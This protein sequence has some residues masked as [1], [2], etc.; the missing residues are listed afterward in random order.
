[1][2]ICLSAAMLMINRC[3]FI[4]LILLI[5]PFYGC[6][7]SAP[8]NKLEI[9]YGPSA[10]IQRQLTDAELPAL[11][12]NK[13]VSYQHEVKPILENRC[14]AC[15]ACYDAPCQLKLSAFDGL[16]RGASKAKVYDSSRM[17]A[18][19]PTRLFTDASTV[20]QWRDRDFFPILNE[21][22]E[23]KLANLDNSLLAKFLQLKRLN[24]LP[25][26]G[27]LG[28]E[29]TLQ[30][31][32]EESCTKM[33]EYDAFQRK[34]PQWGMPYALPGLSLDQEYTL[35]RWLQQGARIEPGA[36]LSQQSLVAIKRWET[37]FNRPSL[38]QQLVS[39]YIYEHLFIGHLYFQT[40]KDP[41][42]F[43]LVRSSTPPG[44]PIQ[45]IASA[46]PYDD[47]GS[48]KFYYRLRQYRES[49][50]D[51]THFAYKLDE[52]KLQR[53]NELFFLPQY[54][55][56][57][58][59]DYAVE[60]AS[61]P[62]KTFQQLPLRSRHHF[63]LD[64]AQYFV[65]GFIKGPV[66]RGQA[67]LN[68]I[69]DRFWVFFTQPSDKFKDEVTE[70]LAENNYILALPGQEGDAIGLFGFLDFDALGAEYMRKK[71]VFINNVFSEQGIDLSL[72]WDGGGWNTNAALTV[73]RHFDSATV[74][75]GFVGKV[76]LTSWFVD[77]PIFERL[78]YLL[79]SGFN[80]Y[81][82]AGHQI[83]SR[84]Y[85]DVLRQDAE[86]N[87][88]RLLPAAK[89]QTIYDSW[90]LGMDGPRVLEPLF[91]KE[92]EVG[93]AYQ[94]EQPV[95]E[96]YAKIK[97]KLGKATG[98]KNQANCEDLIC[99]EIEQQMQHLEN[100]QGQN[101]SVLP[102][103]SLLRVK[104]PENKPDRVYSLVV[105]KALSNISFT[106]AEGAR[107][108]PEHDTLTVVPGFVG[109]YPNYIF[110]VEA[111]RLAEFIRLL[112]NKLDHQQYEQ[113]YAEFG[114][115]RTNP[116]IW[117]Q[118]DWLNAQFKNNKGVDA[119]LLDLSRYSNY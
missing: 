109:S 87:F 4:L 65:S 36:A 93:I 13:L 76:P 51:K 90:Y 25:E 79:V 111:Q 29:Y 27:K 41:E 18:A 47:P 22:R 5:A 100:V 59:P 50:V 32:R 40:S 106:I 24:P 39:R 97:T 58:L 75:R 20:Q 84:T 74:E 28:P 71:D 68:S 92:L 43:K 52:K 70:F 77:Y 63:L 78:H 83:A 12:E 110:V 115:R 72:V 53:Y 8:N 42:F 15:H 10:P 104:M 48:E 45:E 49:I 46:R 7:K 31:N 117:I 61:N 73:F 60:N 35:L 113:F 80:V 82:P 11:A 88:L 14:V 94:T 103:L 34:H 37:W 9:L 105:N 89:R 55:V 33:E 118:Y 98:A 112:S 119:G 26:S 67:A 21:R 102:E 56:D 69:R 44:V 91:N 1:M 2:S 101:L 54:A 64:D 81:G 96:L 17:T 95:R 108:R 66:C 107:R 30:L 57:K 19:T 99:Q 85:M 16:Q 23:T 116:D 6:S 62:F 114:I 38:K 86:N 3:G